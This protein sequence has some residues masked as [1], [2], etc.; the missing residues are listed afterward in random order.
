MDADGSAD[1]QATRAIPPDLVDQSPFSLENML[2]YFSG[3]VL[4]DGGLD[5]NHYVLAYGEIFKFLHMM[6]KV[7]GW[8]ASDVHQKTSVLRQLRLGQHSD[9]YATIQSMV[10]SELQAK[11]DETDVCSMLA[12]ATSFCQFLIVVF[13]VSLALGTIQ[14]GR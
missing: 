6:G 2:Q 14:T 1:G 9:S 11:E 5:M 8:V 13:L 7:F 10:E 3:V 4:P 12:H